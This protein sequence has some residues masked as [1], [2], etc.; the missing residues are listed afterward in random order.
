MHGIAFHGGGSITNDRVLDVARGYS[1]F[2]TAQHDSNQ[3]AQPEGERLGNNAWLGCMAIHS[4]DLAINFEADEVTAGTTGTIRDFVALATAGGAVIDA[5]YRPYE[6]ISHWDVDSVWVY[7]VGG[8]TNSFRIGCD[9]MQAGD[10]KTV[11]HHRARG[12][13][14]RG[15]GRTG[16][17]GPQ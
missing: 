5:A 8:S 6:G 11:G 13:L 16:G 15:E 1:D 12:E 4:E 10:P 14:R 7:P 9:V 2:A 17:S 3:P